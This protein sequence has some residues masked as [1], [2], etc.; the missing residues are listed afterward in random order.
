MKWCSIYHNHF[1]NPIHSVILMYIYVSSLRLCRYGDWSQTSCFSDLLDSASC[2]IWFFCILFSLLA[3]CDMW[4]KCAHKNTFRV[5]V[6]LLCITAVWL[7]WSCAVG[8]LSSCPWL[9]RYRY[10]RMLEEGSFRGRTADFVYMFLFG[11]VLM[12]VSFSIH[13][14]NNNQE[15]IS[16][17]SHVS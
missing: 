4:R 11:G 9:S 10:C 3:I 13:H 12:T 2:S 7:V 5:S 17:S 6:C 16:S 1:I 8:H 14:I 15:C